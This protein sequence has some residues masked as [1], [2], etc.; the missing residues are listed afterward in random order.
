MRNWDVCGEMKKVGGEH[1]LA[2]DSLSH[3]ARTSANLMFSATSRARSQAPVA[4]REGSIPL[5][6]SFKVGTNFRFRH[7][8]TSSGNVK[9]QYAFREDQQWCPTSSKRIRFVDESEDV[10]NIYGDD[11]AEPDEIA[12]LA[13]E[14][15]GDSSP[16]ATSH[17]QP[18]PTQG[19]IWP[20]TGRSGVA[21]EPNWDVSPQ[22]NSRN[23]FQASFAGTRCASFSI[24]EIRSPTA[25]D[26]CASGSTEVQSSNQAETPALTLPCAERWEAE[27]M[28][29]FTD[30]IAPIFDLCNPDQYF[31]STIPQIAL[32]F[33]VLLNAVFAVSEKHLV[34]SQHAGSQTGRA[35]KYFD[36]CTQNIARMSAEQA[37]GVNG[38]L[39][40]AVVLLSFCESIEVPLPD[41]DALKP[42][43]KTCTLLHSITES[44]LAGAL[45]SAVF[46]AGLRQAIY[47][48]MIKQTPITPFIPCHLLDH[49]LE[50]AED[51]VWANRMVAH[52]LSVISYCF[53][54]DKRPSTYDSLCSYAAAWTEAKPS[55]F[56]PVFAR[57]KPREGGT[58]PE[59]LLLSEAAVVGT[60][61]YH[62]A[63][64]LL[65]AHNPK[66]PRLGKGQ[67]LAASLMVDEIKKDVSVI[68]GIAE[69]I[70]KVNPAYVAASM[71]VALGGD[72]FTRRDEHEALFSILIETEKEY[73]WSTSLVQQH[74]KEAWEWPSDTV[75]YRPSSSKISI[76][77]R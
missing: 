51:H 32:A 17:S 45:H 40:A 50:P 69:S 16:S 4:D 30:R 47:A 39:S 3:K 21:T 5:V 67:R 52:L 35:R 9:S 72:N 29:H 38:S 14:A 73:G 11:D 77:A 75:I 62:L 42:P 41:P 1:E 37:P 58:F 68:C 64:I 49:P 25:T 10:A 57:Q 8:S 31:S 7:I 33:P 13:K 55:S 70:G 59:I 46:W 61:Y 65:T 20:E 36:E 34:Y 26:S 2:I 22:Q 18:T 63:R 53:G 19:P 44:A 23:R 71:A 66:M 54:D 28:R 6:Q 12:E 48:A 76:P 43:Q 60:Q 56:S 74:M 27:L 24:Q 15:V